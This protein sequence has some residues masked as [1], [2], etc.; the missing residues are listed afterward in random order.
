MLIVIGLCHTFTIGRNVNFQWE[1]EE[2][3]GVIFSP[4]KLMDPFNSKKDV[5]RNKSK[6]FGAYKSKF[7]EGI[8]DK[9]VSKGKIIWL[10][11]IVRIIVTFP[12]QKIL[13][14]PYLKLCEPFC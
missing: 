13:L 4:T 12:V 6:S 3:K 7:L 5:K 11:V 9:T 1:G 10:I 2:N 8:D 14:M